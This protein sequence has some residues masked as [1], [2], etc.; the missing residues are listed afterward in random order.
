MDPF[1]ANP[2][3]VDED[4]AARTSHKRAREEGELVGEAAD[5]SRPII[6]PT[7]DQVAEAQAE[8]A[9]ESAAAAASQHSAEAVAEQEGLPSGPVAAELA[10][11]RHEL[12]GLAGAAQAAGQADEACVSACTLRLQTLVA[13]CASAGGA[14]LVTRGLQPRHIGLQ[15]RSSISCTPTCPGARAAFEAVGLAE[16]PEPALTIVTPH[17]AAAECSGRAAARFVGAVLLPRV[18]ALVKPASRALFHVALSLIAHHPRALGD[19]LLLP[20]MWLP[21]MNATGGG[22][23]ASRGA[24]PQA[25][26]AGRLLKEMPAAELSRLLGLFLRGEGGQGGQG[27]EGGQQGGQPSAWSEAQVELLEKVLSQ[28]PVLPAEEL[29]ELLQQADANV[30][31][32]RA[33]VKFGQLLLTLARG[34]GSQLDRHQLSLAKRVTEQ[35]EKAFVKKPA[36]AALAKQEA[37][38][39]AG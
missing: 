27:G 5:G 2:W 37:A 23:V 22:A 31:A 32:L 4:L 6:E 33:S 11:L 9:P 20:L 7:R 36:L 14:R 26:A 39:G 38:L 13:C 34:Y 18:R 15:V 1:A 21:A 10:A 3:A 24:T 12:S 35:L 16:A 28:R 25:E 8:P 30:D 29:H 17:F 19:E